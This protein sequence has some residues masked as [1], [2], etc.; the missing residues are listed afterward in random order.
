MA[1]QS[2]RVDRKTVASQMIAFPSTS[3]PHHEGVMAFLSVNNGNL[4]AIARKSNGT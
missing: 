4:G 3:A 2:S 1:R